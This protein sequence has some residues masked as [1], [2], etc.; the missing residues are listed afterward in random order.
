MKPCFGYIRV[1]TQKQGEGVSLEAQKDAITAFASHNN[2][3]VTE[4]FEE[5]ETAAKSGRPIFSRMLKMLERGRAYGLIVHKIDRSA[6]NL[7]DWAVIGELSDKGIDVYFATE[8]LDFRS[9]GGRLTADIQAV[10][11]ADYIRNLRD[12]TKKGIDGRLKQG[13]YP[14]RAPVGYLDNGRGQPKSPCP[15]KAPLIKQLFSLYTT[16]SHSIRTLEHEATRIGLRNVAG[17]PITKHG[18]ETILR[19][20]FYCGIIEI[21]RTGQTFDGVHKPII[22]IQTFRQVQDIKSGKAGKKVTRHNHLYRGLFRC[23]LCNA[24]LTPERQKGRV[25]YRCQLSTCPTTTIRE[26]VIDEQ[27]VSSLEAYE[28]NDNEAAQLAKDWSDWRDGFDHA[29]NLRSIDLRIT[30][31]RQR[32]ERLTDLL[33]DGSIDKND[34]EAR[35][36]SLI[37]EQAMMNE[38]RLK[39]T[40]SGPNPEDIQNFLEL[41]KTLSLLYRSATND[42]KREMVENCFSNRTLSGKN[43]VLEPSNWLCEVKL[44]GGVPVGDPRRPTDRT[45]F[46]DET[47]RGLL[48]PFETMLERTKVVQLESNI[49]ATPQWKY[50]L[51]NLRKESP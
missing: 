39:A 44:L 3:Q 34:F 38:E 27:V 2:L 48:R 32:L 4:W 9:R 16:G 41:T 36:R 23:A 1:S 43:L 8:S 13:L 26:D 35:K 25:Y 15:I 42:E 10:I 45:F 24:P 33:I 21:R 46:T 37:M 17:G 22:D 14:F 51:S 19:N 50:N 49:P 29:E 40:K 7:K 20:P 31:T 47:L 30:Q 18:I 28:L 5:K 11:A 12:E 6:R